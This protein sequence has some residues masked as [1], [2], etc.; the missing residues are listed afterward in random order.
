MLLLKSFLQE[1]ISFEK[2]SKEKSLENFIKIIKPQSHSENIFFGCRGVKNEKLV[3]HVQELGY[4]FPDCWKIS[5]N[6]LRGSQ[7]DLHN[8]NID[9]ES[10]NHYLK[11]LESVFIIIKDHPEYKATISS[12]KTLIF[13]FPKKISDLEHFYTKINAFLKTHGFKYSYHTHSFTTDENAWIYFSEEIFDKAFK[14]YIASSK[15]SEDNLDDIVSFAINNYTVTQT[16][17]ASDEYYPIQ[18]S[19]EEPKLP[20]PDEIQ[21]VVQIPKNTDPFFQH[22]IDL[23][24]EL[25]EDGEDLSEFKF[26]NFAFEHSKL[27][28]FL[29]NL[30]DFWKKYNK[31]N[32]A[33]VFYH[34]SEFLYLLCKVKNNTFDKESTIILFDYC[35]HLNH[36]YKNENLWPDE[37]KPEIKNIL[38]WIKSLYPII[39][40][41][42]DFTKTKP[43]LDF[44]KEFKEEINRQDLIEQWT[45]KEDINFSS[46]NLNFFCIQ[47]KFREYIFSEI[48]ETD[49]ETKII[50]TKIFFDEMLDE[51]YSDKTDYPIK[52][53]RLFDDIISDKIKGTNNTLK[54]LIKFTKEIDNISTKNKKYDVL[55]T[56]TVYK[57]IPQFKKN[58]KIEPS[59]I[60]DLYKIISKSNN[61][62]LVF[63]DDYNFKITKLEMLEQIQYL[64][65]IYFEYKNFHNLDYQKNKFDEI[66]SKLNLSFDECKTKI[67]DFYNNRTPLLDKYF[68]SSFTL[69]NFCEW[70]KTENERNLF[71]HPYFLF[72]EENPKDHPE[73]IL[74]PFSYYT[75]FLEEIKDN[76][77]N[78]E[79]ETFKVFLEDLAK[80]LKINFYKP[81]EIKTANELTIFRENLEQYNP[82]F[83][84]KITKPSE[85]K[86]NFQIFISWIKHYTKSIVILNTDDPLNNISMDVYVKDSENEDKIKE[87]KKYL[88]KVIFEMSELLSSGNI[89]SDKKLSEK[90]FSQ[91]SLDDLSETEKLKL[92]TEAKNKLENSEII[93]QVDFKELEYINE[94]FKHSYDV[95]SD[96]VHE[97]SKYNNKFQEQFRSILS[98]TTFY[99]SIKNYTFGSTKF[100]KPFRQL[101]KKNPLE[102]DNILTLIKMFF[103]AGVII[104]EPLIIIRGTKTNRWLKNK[105]AG[106]FIIEPAFLS[107]TIRLS[108]ATDDFTANGGHGMLYQIYFPKGMKGIYI[109]EITSVKGEQEVLLPP[110]CIFKILS[111]ENRSQCKNM[112]LRCEYGFLYKLLYIGSATIDMADKLFQDNNKWLELRSQIVPST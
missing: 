49:V 92:F 24:S 93:D 73:N 4:A 65:S 19:L 111:I 81:L 38:K 31:N 57:K 60:L 97:R 56:P 15:N 101:T 1:A 55:N 20:D 77:K 32:F 48:M 36:A 54:S 23:Q 86:E 70:F 41:G 66:L 7:I 104:D 110:G 90:I 100:N 52:I 17:N 68:K 27:L 25:M 11:I 63:R 47:T 12:M 42:T 67:L 9:S 71:N 29:G 82:S 83:P 80:H 96:N 106:D 98:N 5:I 61:L 69:M 88:N 99:R 45:K 95:T 30:K 79:V 46:F 103:T 64:N 35:Y 8:F 84:N 44:V 26:I 37:L 2:P 13:H 6:D 109:E 59:I 112:K 22:I 89:Y 3:V 87:N 91:I 78:L 62:N 85:N 28:E 50:K 76:N 75:N 14:V 58:T 74:Y 43:I 51:V 53:V 40:D 16:V 33:K 102:I 105:V 108:T 18:Q 107:T 21:S 10:K 94:Q 72:D 34:V 39:N